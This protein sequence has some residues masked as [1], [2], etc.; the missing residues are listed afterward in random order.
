MNLISISYLSYNR[1]N[2]LTNRINLL[3]EKIKYY[4]LENYITIQIY[5]NNSHHKELKYLKS[6]LD[7]ENFDGLSINLFESENNYGFAYNLRKAIDNS[8][9]YYTWL[10]SDDDYLNLDTLNFLIHSLKDKQID[11]LS[12]NTKPIKKD[13][14]EIYNNNNIFIS[15][16]SYPNINNLI[17]NNKYVDIDK[18]FGFIS[19]NIVRT[20]ILR[21]SNY[22]ISNK[23]EYLNKNNYLIKAIN[24]LSFSK[25]SKFALIEHVP[26]VFQ[27]IENGSYFY[28]DTKIRIKTFIFDLMQIFCFIKNI[29]DIN[30][31]KVTLDYLQRK[32]FL[33]R[34]FWISLK[35]ED[36]LK[37]EYIL[38]IYNKTSSVYPSLLLIYITPKFVIRF[39]RNII[40]FIR[41]YVIFNY[42]NYFNK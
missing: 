41:V 26:I 36:K 17:F 39:I 14:F 21:D 1:I 33:N 29:E 27:N 3:A 20:N 11:F 8:S 35:I 2:L 28:N 9:S 30:F 7:Q 12:L 5:D 22:F 34:S 16:Y 18:N 32:L 15:F 13:K 38:F 10:L 6:L 40:K 4:E 25:S 24:Y 42:K 19:S 31:N 23:H 37:I